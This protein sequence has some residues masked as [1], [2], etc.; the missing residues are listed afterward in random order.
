MQLNTIFNIMP[1]EIRNKIPQE[2]I[3]EIERHINN[4]L[5]TAYIWLEKYKR[6][7]QGK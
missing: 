4:Q 3:K 5:N 1:A 2:Y 6:E 7:H